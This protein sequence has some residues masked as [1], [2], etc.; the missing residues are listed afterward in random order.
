MAIKTLNTRLVKLEL[1]YRR[2]LKCA[3]CRYALRETSREET[4]N[5]D[6]NSG[7]ILYTKCWH[8][9]TQFQVSLAG[10]NEFDREART[11]IYNSDPSKKFTDERVH[12]AFIYCGLAKQKRHPSHTGNSTSVKTA[13][14]LTVAEEKRIRE[15]EEVKKRAVEFRLKQDQ[16]IKLFAKGPKFFPIDHKIQQIGGEFRVGRY[17]DG[18][19][20]TLGLDVNDQQRFDLEE[21]LEPL[22][23]DLQTM[24]MRATC[25]VVLWGKTVPKTLSEMRSIERE[26]KSKFDKAIDACRQEK[27]R[28]EEQRKQ[29]ETD[30]KTKCEAAARENMERQR[31]QVELKTRTDSECSLDQS[32]NLSSRSSVAPTQS[33]PIIK[34]RDDKLEQ[35]V[36]RHNQTQT[37]TR[38]FERYEQ[39]RFETDERP[40]FQK[41]RKRYEKVRLPET[42]N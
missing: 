26:I 34:D 40:R 11:I 28:Q 8:C 7:D 23:A 19:T 29:K 38:A 36:A 20:E 33:D 18:F 42:I 15:R 13:A 37:Q 16:R 39:P 27:N 21:K 22:V 31:V 12:A 2:V 9:G 35:F 3:W 5:F 24:K 4:R 1:Q 41:T 32:V 17:S 6:R 10:L 14:F 25:E 30:E